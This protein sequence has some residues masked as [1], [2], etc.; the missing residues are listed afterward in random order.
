[1]IAEDLGIKLEAVGLDDL[2]NAKRINIDK[3]NTTIVDGA[4]SKADLEGRVKQIRAQI[5]DTT[6]DYDREKLKNVLQN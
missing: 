3:D 5:D 6:S 4:G 1:M 2:G